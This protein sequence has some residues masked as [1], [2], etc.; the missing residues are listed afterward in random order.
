MVSFYNLVF[1]FSDFLEQF[2][3]SLTGTISPF[4]SIQRCT[5]TSFKA[6][7]PGLLK[8]VHSAKPRQTSKKATNFMI[9]NT[10]EM[11]I[12]TLDTILYI[13]IAL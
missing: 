8:V 11:E 12:I 7:F 2:C 3:C 6:L 9:L 1:K 4:K 13:S 10:A 5:K